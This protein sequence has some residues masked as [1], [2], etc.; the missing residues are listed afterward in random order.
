MMQLI[1]NKEADFDLENIW[2]Y[3][4]DNFGLI[5]ADRYLQLIFDEFK[6]LQKYPQSGKSQE[7][8]REGYRSAIVKSYLIF[9][10]IKNENEIQII[11]ILHESMQIEDHL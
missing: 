7:H 2:D 10:I 9:Y 5:Q 6:Y 3:S 11:R 8:I 4:F 1:V